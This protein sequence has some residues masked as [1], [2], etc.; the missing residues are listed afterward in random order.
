MPSHLRANLW[1]FAMSLL[2]CCVV[3]PGLLLGIG[4][5]AFPNQAEGSLLFDREGKPIGS[6]LIGQ[7]FTA[8]EFFQPRPSAASY[9]ASASG[10]SNWGA[11]NPLLR[12]RVARQ[13][14]PIARYQS[15]EK[16]HQLVVPDIEH[17]FRE[18]RFQQKPGIV[19]QWAQAHPALAR[20]WVTSDVLNSDAVL[21]WKAGHPDEVC[22]WISENPDTPEPKPEDL[23]VPYFVDFGKTHAGR[24]SRCQPSTRRPDGRAKNLWSPRR[25]APICSRRSSICGCRTIRALS[26][27]RSRPIW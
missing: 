17:W 14:G 27:N 26:W 1:L 13:L 19:T 6:R 10:A 12:D 21:S 9:N 2:L 3:Y 4:H 5:V 22:R 24:I 25:L 8:D 7:P 16:A 18:D 20:N 23:A 11:N 15:G